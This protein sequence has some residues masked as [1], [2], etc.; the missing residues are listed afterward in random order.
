MKTSEEIYNILKEKFGEEVILN[1]N[2]A[3][4]IDA[5]I[6]VNPS[7]IN[8]VSKFLRD[9]EELKFD[10]LMLLSGV[11]DANGT[12]VKDENEIETIQ[13]GTLSV[14]YHCHSMEIGHKVT[15]RVSTP[16]ENPQVQ[17]VERIWRAADWHEREAFDMFGI[18]FLNHHDLRR[19]LMPDDW[20]ERYP[21]RKDYVDPEYYN[22]IKIPY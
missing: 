4:P 5:I 21:L 17:S 10:T 14:Y 7:K 6:E 19:I 2:T 13:G 15:L 12:K 1:F 16:R 11:D 22:G 3:E 8:E 20:G 9:S 18:K